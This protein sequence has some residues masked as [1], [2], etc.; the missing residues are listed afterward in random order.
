ME[1][2]LEINFK[3]LNYISRRSLVKLPTPTF[4]NVILTKIMTYF[5]I[6]GKITKKEKLESLSIPSVCYY[7]AK[8]KFLSDVNF[9]S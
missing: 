9:P 7:E 4:A 6:V 2:Q 8:I 3:H 5:L 1:T